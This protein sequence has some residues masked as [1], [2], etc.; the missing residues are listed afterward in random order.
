MV[1]E[2][3]RNQV[4]RALADSLSDRYN[5]GQYNH[6]PF[7]CPNIFSFVRDEVLLSIGERPQATGDELV[8]EAI[9]SPLGFWNQYS[10]WIPDDK[11]KQLAYEFVENHEL[12]SLY[13][14]VAMRLF[15]VIMREY[16][17]RVEAQ[18]SPRSLEDGEATEID[19][20]EEEDENN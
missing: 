18:R 1:E 2:A 12:L 9:R 7:S 6:H 3:S 20:E 8:N 10:R 17:D 5:Y 16:Y 4:V 15:T 11:Y 19:T 13:D 14:W